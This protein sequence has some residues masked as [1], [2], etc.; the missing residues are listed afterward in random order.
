MIRQVFWLS[1]HS[2]DCAFPQSFP[3]SDILQ[4]SSLIT[5]AGPL[6]VFTGFPIM[7]SK[8]HLISYSPEN[9][10]RCQAKS[11]GNFVLLDMIRENFVTMPP[12][13]RA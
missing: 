1:D 12:T 2:T 8:L 13:T 10:Y 11:H 6:P 5:E 4:R 7:Q 3:C 9:R